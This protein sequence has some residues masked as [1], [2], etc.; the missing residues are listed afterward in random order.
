VR[1]NRS[2]AAVEISEQLRSCK[3]FC[4]HGNRQDTRKR[5]PRHLDD[6]LRMADRGRA[7]FSAGNPS[8]LTSS[9]VESCDWPKKL[10]FLRCFLL[11]ERAEPRL[12]QEGCRHAR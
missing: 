11:P 2:R 8:S 7:E 10:T 5:H 9:F 6:L 3:N 4:G 12:R 1:D